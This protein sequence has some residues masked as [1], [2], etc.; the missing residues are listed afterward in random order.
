MSDQENARAAV[1]VLISELKK[2]EGYRYSWRANIAMAFV[3]EFDRH[4]RHLG[5]HAIANK[6]ADNFLNMLCG[7]GK[8]ENESHNVGL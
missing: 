1:A 5:V 2:C 7:A 6:A 3:D 8:E 4:H